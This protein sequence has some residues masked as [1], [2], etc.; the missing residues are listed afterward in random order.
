MMTE[1]KCVLGY[2]SSVNRNFTPASK[3]FE[4]ACALT[5]LD[6][7]RENIMDVFDLRLIWIEKGAREALSTVYVSMF[8]N[9]R[10]V[11]YLSLGRSVTTIMVSLVLK[12]RK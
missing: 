4:A 11:D 2:S 3:S 6:I 9:K 7:Y 8:V 1:G 10:E 5:G 12:L